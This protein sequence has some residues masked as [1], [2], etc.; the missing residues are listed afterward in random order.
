MLI[1]NLDSAC[2]ILE[3]LDKRLPNT[4]QVAYR[5]I[6]LE[7][8]RGSLDKVSS[9]YEG[10]ISSYKNITIAS[11]LSIKYARFLCKLRHD[12]TLAVAVLNKALEKD[13]SN[14]R[15]Y[16]NLV[17]IY[18]Q[19]SPIDVTGVVSIFD[20]FLQLPD[21]SPQSK[22][23]FSQKKLEFLEDFGTDVACVLRATE[24]VA[25]WQ[26][27]AKDAKKESKEEASTKDTSVPPPKKPKSDYNNQAA[28]GYGAQQGYNY[29]GYQQSGYYNQGDYYNWQQQYGGGY[30]GNQGGWGGGGGGGGG[31]NYS[32]YWR[33]SHSFCIFTVYGSF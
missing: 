24:E 3:G 30:G 6:N 15:L 25:V 5:R 14:T 18:M 2:E 26:K 8:R 19:K 20:R 29:P 9:L 33:I 7:R 16:L 12:Q 1:G 10:Y 23:N 13:K 32:Y 11:A 21:A 22:H 28:A 4:L 27:A 17:D 31:G